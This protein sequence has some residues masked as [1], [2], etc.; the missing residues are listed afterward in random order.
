MSAYHGSNKNFD[1]AKPSFT[2]RGH[3]DKG[4]YVLD[5]EGISLHVTPYKWIALVYTEYRPKYKHKNIEYYFNFGVPIKY[6]DDDFINKIVYID[7]KKSLEYSLNKIYGKGGYLYTFSKNKFIW[8]KGLG[9]NELISYKEEKPKKI[10]FIKN[11]VKEMEKL[12]VKFK[13]IDETKKLNF[14]IEIV[15]F[16]DL[17]LL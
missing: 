6:K 2:Q 11:P 12:G 13:F 3:I 5:Y 16:F 4:K 14:I 17:N 10:E 15:V 8:K 7:G 9:A 1:I